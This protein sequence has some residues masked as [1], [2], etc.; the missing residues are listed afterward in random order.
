MVTKTLHF[1]VCGEGLTGI[2]RQMYCFEGKQEAAMSILENLDGITITQARNVCTGKA[3]L[4]DTKDGMMRYIEKDEP[5]FIEN[6]A[7]HLQHVAKQID[8]ADEEAMAL[9][10]KLDNP[11]IDEDAAYAIGKRVEQSSRNPRRE[12]ILRA[13]IPIK[14]QDGNYSRGVNIVEGIVDPGS[15]QGAPEYAAAIGKTDVFFGN[16]ARIER[17]RKVL[18]GMVDPEVEKV[19][20]LNKEVTVT[21]EELLEKLCYCEVCKEHPSCGKDTYLGRRDEY[22][23]L[24]KERLFATYPVGEAI[25]TPAGEVY[26]VMGGYIPKK[27]LD[28]YSN[29]I[30]DR[31][32]GMKKKVSAADYGRPI[33]SIDELEEQ[34]RALHI[35]VLSNAGFMPLEVGILATAFKMVIEHFIEERMKRLGLL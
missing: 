4:E 15:C 31:L 24:Y 14:N 11:I 12:E 16:E 28:D 6:Y 22:C 34:R 8:E 25:T 33:Y 3:H 13:G 10:I 1:S 19:P 35:A 29:A 2:V 20:G 26:P 5:E 18:E 21:S 27:M 9:L 17:V 7:K 32:R 30:A 23:S